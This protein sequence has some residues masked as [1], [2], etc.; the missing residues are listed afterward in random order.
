[1]TQGV[2]FYDVGVEAGKLVVR[3]L[4]GEKP[5]NFDVVQAANNDIRIDLKAA[6]KVGI[7]IPK[8]IIESATKVIQ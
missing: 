8:A 4:K 2:N 1:M 6:K 3:I 7:V 5:S